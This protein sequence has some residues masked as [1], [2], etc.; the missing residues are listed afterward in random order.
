MIISVDPV[1]CHNVLELEISLA[2]N[3]SRPK[4]VSPCQIIFL[5]F[6]PYLRSIPCLIKNISCPSAPYS[7][8]DKVYYLGLFLPVLEKM[9]SKLWEKT[10]IR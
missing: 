5:I 3:S 10:P 2:C 1:H 4:H 7:H 9:Y 8:S 6:T